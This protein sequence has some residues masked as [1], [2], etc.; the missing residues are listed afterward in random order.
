MQ[1][2]YNK[3]WLVNK[4]RSTAGILLPSINVLCQFLVV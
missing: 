1:I 3:F 4:R 2:F